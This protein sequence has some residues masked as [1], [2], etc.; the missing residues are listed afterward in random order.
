[1]CIRDR[2]YS[3][4]TLNDVFRIDAVA[5]NPIRFATNDTERMRILNSGNVGIGTDSPGKTLEVVGDI[6]ASGKLIGD[7]LEVTHLTS[8][9]TTSSQNILIQNITS[10]GDSIFGDAISDT[11]TFNG[12]ITASGN[13]SASGT[14]TSSGFHLPD[15]GKITIGDV[16]DLSLYHN[17]NHLSLIHI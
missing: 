17:G 6:S 3:I 9:F 13:I 12:H 5:N 11:H 2:V 4:K 14:I 8:S 10:S 1:M 16:G 7:S 15:D